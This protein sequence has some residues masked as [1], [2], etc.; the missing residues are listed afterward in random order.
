MASTGDTDSS[1][2]THAR[3]MRDVMRRVI[4]ANQNWL[5][6]KSPPVRLDRPHMGTSSSVVST[7]R[8][9]TCTS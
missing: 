4:H 7:M 1:M 8:M 6:M 5:L 2:S 3:L 9:G